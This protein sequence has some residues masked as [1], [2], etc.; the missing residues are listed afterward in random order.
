VNRHLVDKIIALQGQIEEL[1]SHKETLQ[2]SGQ[3]YLSPTDPEAQLMRTRD[4]K[5]PAYNI[6]SVVDE[7]FHM[8]AAT[9]VLTAPQDHAALPVMVQSVQRELG[10]TPHQITADAGYYTP[11]D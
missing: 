10:I 6:Q 3:T 4:G 2:N 11:D 9:E 1:T 7:H 8:I 5:M